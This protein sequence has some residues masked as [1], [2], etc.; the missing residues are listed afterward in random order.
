MDTILIVSI[1]AVTVSDIL[2][3]PGEILAWYHRLIERLPG[4]LYK[5]LGG[6]AKCLAG[7]VALWYGFEVS[8]E[9]FINVILTVFI[10]ELIS[11]IYGRI[12]NR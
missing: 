12:A 7:Q 11:L 9:H 8:L 4:W 10:T 1:T 2:G 5:P 3:E 6:C